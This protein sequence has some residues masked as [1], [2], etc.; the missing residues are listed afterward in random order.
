[1]ATIN[2]IIMKI[3]TLFGILFIII[4]GFLSAIGYTMYADA[5]FAPAILLYAP[6]IFTL[7]LGMVIFPGS[8][9]TVKE[10]SANNMQ[11]KDILSD[12]KSIHKIVWLIAGL[13]GFIVYIM[14]D[15]IADML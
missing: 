7:G 11:L 6:I 5:G 14:K 10:F 8:N 12:T 1:M 15:T 3:G 4:G 9:I 13:L 2:R